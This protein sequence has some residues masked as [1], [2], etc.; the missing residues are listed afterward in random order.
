VSSLASRGPSNGISGIQ[1]NDKGIEAVRDFPVPDKVHG[2]SILEGS[3]KI[4]RSSCIIFFD[5]NKK[6]RSKVS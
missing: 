3:L 2:V 4:F 6:R 1:A 5:S